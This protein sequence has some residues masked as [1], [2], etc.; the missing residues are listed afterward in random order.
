MFCKK[1]GANIA[2]GASFCKSCGAE[3]SAPAQQPV[4]QYQQPVAQVQYAY[5]Q[6]YAQPKKKKTG[7]II[8]LIAGG[9]A[10][11]ALVIV[12]I[13]V[14]AG[15][16]SGSSNDDGSY[17]GNWNIKKVYG[18]ECEGQGMTLTMTGSYYQVEMNGTP[19]EYVEVTRKDGNTGYFTAGQ[20]AQFEVHEN[21]LTMYLDGAEY[22]VATRRQKNRRRTRNC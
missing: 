4:Q 12:L 10:I 11:I 2:D 13:V 21:E 22:I 19:I 14:F 5:P 16:G 6:G 8:G 7:L 1:C 9:A 17:Y 15:G 18:Q 3:Q 20:T